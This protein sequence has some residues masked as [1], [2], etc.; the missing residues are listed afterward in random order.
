MRC[1]CMLARSSITHASSPRRGGSTTT[2]E[3]RCPVLRIS[4][5]S[6]PLSPHKNDAFSMPLFAAFSFAS[7]IACG[8]ISAPVKK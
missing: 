5:S 3:K 2:A 4:V 7:A 8:I 1:G 6:S